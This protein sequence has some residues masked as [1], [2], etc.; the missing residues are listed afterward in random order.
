MSVNNV[1]GV[2]RVVLPTTASRQADASPPRASEAHTAVQVDEAT[3]QPVPPRFP[4]LSRLAREL[5]PAS[6]QPS[7][8]GSVPI[9][10]EKLDKQA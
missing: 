4:W 3:Q 2:G 1:T 7:P 8:Y 10:G 6:K 9:L 5:E